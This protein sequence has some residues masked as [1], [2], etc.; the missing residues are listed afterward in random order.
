MSLAD[1][2]K[3]KVF[4]KEEIEIEYTEAPEI[5]KDRNL[6]E[7]KKARDRADQLRERTS[8]YMQS[9][10]SDLEEMKDYSD[11]EDL[12]VVDDV[13][14]D[15]AQSQKLTVKKA[16]FS[17]KIDKHLQ[18]LRDFLNDFNDV[19]EKQGQ[20]MRR[21]NKR[22]KLLSVLEDINDHV[23]NT[24]EFVSS[25]Y[26]AVRQYRKIKKL[27]E[28]LEDIDTEIK[29]KR[30]S[31][32]GI[33]M[34]GLEEEREEAEEKIEEL[35]D[36]EEWEKLQSKK[37]NLSQLKQEKENLESKISKNISTMRRGLKK[38]VYQVQNDEIE[39]ESNIDKLDMITEHEYQG[40]GNIDKELS[41][42]R[43]KIKEKELLEPRQIQNFV[44]S[45]K[46]LEGFNEM[47][48]RMREL[49]SEIKELEDE[50]EG[51]EVKEEVEDLE[52]DLRNIED[53]IERKKERKDNLESDI[54]ALEAERSEKIEMLEE[55]MSKGLNAEVTVKEE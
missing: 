48:T 19:S 43:K 32:N 29:E 5:Y 7:I 50:I 3:Q 11:D 46:E 51:M 1:K 30:M 47:I 15:F 44:D 26:T 53:K 55:E 35:K 22:T 27:S 6:A 2:L 25:K 21:I 23:E 28:E 17:E 39:F 37:D 10:K 38:L 52:R 16:E 24:Q 41:E 45:S 49:K 9:L 20:V 33:S 42:A 31:K 14:E 18:D 34:E 13:A 54:L 8:K 12:K 40:A 36:S 4:G